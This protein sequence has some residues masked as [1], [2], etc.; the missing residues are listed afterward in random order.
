[1]KFKPLFALTVTKKNTAAA[2][3]IY[4]DLIFDTKEKA[5]SGAKIPKKA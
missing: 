4:Q 3:G 2:A 1:M 5:F